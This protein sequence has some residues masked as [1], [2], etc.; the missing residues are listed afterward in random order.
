M[1]KKD[2]AKQKK[3]SRRSASDEQ[4]R[5]TIVGS[6]IVVLLD[7]VKATGDPPALRG[8]RALHRNRLIRL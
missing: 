4:R 1:P 6:A 5:K 2:G 7:K 8:A 3:S